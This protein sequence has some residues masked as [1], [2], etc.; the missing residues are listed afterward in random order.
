MYT[1]LQ[2]SPA[3]PSVGQNYKA[4]VTV[5]GQ[6]AFGALRPHSWDCNPHQAARSPALITTEGPAGT[7]LLKR[8]EK[9]EREIGGWFIKF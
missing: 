2:G 7:G 6:R 3:K 9:P 1:A 5:P 4:G 8:G